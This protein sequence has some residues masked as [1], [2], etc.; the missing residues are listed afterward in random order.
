MAAHLE[1]IERCNPRL[2]AIVAMLPPEECLALADDAD[3]RLR[4]R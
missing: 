1:Q 3:A 2:N 4:P